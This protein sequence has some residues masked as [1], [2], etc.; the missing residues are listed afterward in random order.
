MKRIDQKKRS[1]IESTKD[2]LI[3]VIT[4]EWGFTYNNGKFH[5]TCRYSGFWFK[6]LD[7]KNFLVVSYAS[8]SPEIPL[9]IFDI[10]RCTYSQDA[11]LGKS[12]PLSIQRLLQG[13]ELNRDK[14]KIEKIFST[15]LNITQ[16]DLWE[17]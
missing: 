15:P 12:E 4:D 10:F 5:P 14:N 3:R 9:Y 6:D 8:N 7:N 13:I 1:S 2:E 16:E 11:I 17:D